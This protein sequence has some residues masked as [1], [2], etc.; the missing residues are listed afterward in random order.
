MSLLS[1]S[2]DDIDLDEGEDLEQEILDENFLTDDY[3]LKQTQ[4]DSMEDVEELELIVDTH[5]QSLHGL[6]DRLPNLH[7]LKLSNSTIQSI[8]HLGSSFKTVTVL[9]LSRCGLKSFDGIFL[10]PNLIELYAAFND[11]SDLSPLSSLSNLDTLDLDSNEITSL[12]QL[13]YLSPTSI[14]TL[15]LESNPITSDDEYRITALSYLSKLEVL[16]D[17]DVTPT[18][19]KEANS[20]KPVPNRKLTPSAFKREDLLISKEIKHSKA[21]GIFSLDDPL[22]AKFNKQFPL[23]SP[24]NRANRPQTAS[25]LRSPPKSRTSQTSDPPIANKRIRP[26]TA[27]PRSSPNT[28]NTFSKTSSHSDTLSNTL[29]S[30]QFSSAI[31]R[32]SLAMALSYNQPH[33]NP[34]S[35][36]KPTTRQTSAAAVSKPVSF[37]TQDEPSK[38]TTRGVLS[39]GDP[40]N[41]AIV[42]DAARALFLLRHSRRGKSSQQTA[43]SLSSIQKESGQNRMES[44]EAKPKKKQR[45]VMKDWIGY[46]T[47][48]E[49]RL[50]KIRSVSAD[51]RLQE[52]E[53]Q[54]RE[55]LGDDADDEDNPIELRDEAILESVIRRKTIELDS[56][57]N[58]AVPHW[59]ALVRPSTALAL[60][61]LQSEQDAESGAGQLP[62]STS[63]DRDS[64]ITI[65]TRTG[66]IVDPRPATVASGASRK[67]S[68]K[69]EDTGEKMALPG[70]F[71]FGRNKHQPTANIPLTFT[72]SPSPSPLG[73]SDSVHSDLTSSREV[74]FSQKHRQRSP[75][76]SR[77]RTSDLP[78]T[79]QSARRQTRPLSSTGSQRPLSPSALR[80][81]NTPFTSSR[82]P[83][84]PP[85]RR[86][87]TGQNPVTPTIAS[88]GG[89][90]S[91]ASFIDD[92]LMA[93]VVGA[94]KSTPNRPSSPKRTQ[95][96]R[97]SED[98]IS[99]VLRISNLVFQCLWLL[100]FIVTYAWSVHP[101][102]LSQLSSSLFASFA[103]C[104]KK[105]KRS[106][107][108]LFLFLLHYGTTAYLM[109]E[110]TFDLYLLS[111][112]RLVIGTVLAVFAYITL[113]KSITVAFSESMAPNPNGSLLSGIFERS[114]HPQFFGLTLATISV[115]LFTN[116]YVNLLASVILFF[117][118][119]YLAKHEEQDLQLRFGELYILYR[120]TVPMFIPILNPKWNLDEELASVNGARLHFAQQQ[121]DAVQQETQQKN[122]SGSITDIT[123]TPI[124]QTTSSSDQASN[125][126]EQPI[127][128][129]FPSQFMSAKR[130]TRHFNQNEEHPDFSR[131]G[132]V[133][134]ATPRPGRLTRSLGNLLSYSQAFSPRNMIRLLS[135][136]R[137][138]AES[139]ALFQRD[140]FAVSQRNLLSISGEHNQRQAQ[141]SP[142]APVPT[143]PTQRKSGSVQREEEENP[144]NL[145]QRRSVTPSRVVTRSQSRQQGPLS[146]TVA[147]QLEVGD[148]SLAEYG[149]EFV[150]RGKKQPIIPLYVVK[151]EKLKKGE[152]YDCLL[153]GVE[154]N[155]VTIKQSQL[156]PLDKAFVQANLSRFI[157]TNSKK[158]LKKNKYL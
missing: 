29:S 36:S 40:T 129:P 55:L 13:I 82:N 23:P 19:R 14:T 143:R 74:E 105:R 12:D 67:L 44:L 117:S 59:T 4:A 62:P 127:T 39:E 128:S 106:L 42:G 150:P 116:N 46:K 11:I 98:T 138:P 158:W 93:A 22:Y 121:N 120:Y 124:T 108:Y 61:R 131:P 72:D 50:A 54:R 17:I 97:S 9:Y 90:G 130:Q 102:A 5:I 109:P 45:A 60:S 20:F 94:N 49:Q 37:V 80:P 27:V 51:L 30:S 77:Q 146:E 1:N 92:A 155:R 48:I 88:M 21:T 101:F 75:G 152:Q 8:R 57:S 73:E 154:K 34:P 87:A 126:V 35:I 91:S 70:E 71:D 7:E 156:R 119:V 133:H 135:P 104:G 151:I 3:I 53:K 122:A 89:T 47:E 43:Q 64:A 10:F 83:Q 25:L 111:T 78:L 33:P 147:D 81:I 6:G 86:S 18:E 145:R 132:T 24:Q 148:Y 118:L 142:I 15:T 28:Q 63:T 52:A 107:L 149:K 41:G 56:S 141:S 96:I 144:N 100:A 58:T 136:A 113:M 140:S 137:V 16:D 110:R 68:Q 26:G 112:Y 139:A 65:S 134:T 2:D 31:S 123:M 38:Q 79:P 66:G 99:Q 125:A 153:Y 114:R 84:T 85:T 76:T 115:S 32:H 157:S 103:E 95:T 69:Q